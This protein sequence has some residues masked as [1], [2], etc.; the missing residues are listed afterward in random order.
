[1]AAAPYETL[2]G[3]Q[4]LDDLH[5]YFPAILYESTRFHTVQ[6][7]LFY[8]QTAT[9]S[10]FDLFSFGQRAYISA[11]IPPSNAI[12]IPPVTAPAPLNPHS[13]DYVPIRHRMRDDMEVIGMNRLIVELI[14]GMGTGTQITATATVG[15]QQFEDVPVLPTQQ[16]INENT[17]RQH[18]SEEAMCS[19]CQDVMPI[20]QMVRSLNFCG[21]SFHISCIDQWFSRNVHCPICRHDIRETGAPDTTREDEEE[22]N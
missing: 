7:L 22:E 6:D 9:R 12:N 4:L 18:P 19:I 14:R 20:N 13:S 5:N 16:Q 17:T 21:H 8:L 2:Y 15:G 3:V 10:R 11:T 1:M